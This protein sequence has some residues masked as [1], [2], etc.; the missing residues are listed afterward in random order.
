MKKFINPLLYSLG[1]LFILSFI[2]TILNYIGIISGLPLK[3]I[4]ILKT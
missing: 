1:T 4:K 3:I 2:I